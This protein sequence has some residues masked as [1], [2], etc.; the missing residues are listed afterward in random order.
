[1]KNVVI[2]GY[3]YQGIQA[4]KWLKKQN[5]YNFCGFVDNSVYKQG[6]YVGGLK[7]L[8]VDELAGMWDKHNISVIIAAGKWWEI[9][10]QCKKRGI[11][12]EGVYENNGIRRSDYMTFEQL[13]L[14]KEIKLYA[15]DICDLY[16]LNEEN[17]YGLSI[18][19]ADARHIFHNI[20]DSYPL[21][22][23]CISRY[24]LE[25]VLEYIPRE[26][27]KSTL[28][29]ICRILKPESL[30]RITV[31]DFNSPYLRE[32]TMMSQDGEFLFDAG[33]G[34]NYDENGISNGNIYFSTYEDFNEILKQTDF[35]SI[36]WLCYYT[37]DG[38]L[39]KEH[40]DMSKGYNN[41]VKNETDEDVYS[42][43]VDCYK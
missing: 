19:K 12:V 6:N 23:S 31:P 11:P 13:D 9:E 5:C 30:C 37:S 8:S 32:R 33:A 2:F 18:N 35:S 40:I 16:H 28:N 42:M 15:G 7:I 26:L 43:V 17:L 24:E 10:G 29:E 41:R 20:M 21:P 22:D 34:G 36:E 39:H 3:G 1:M 38:V 14:S 25:E 27:Q 4:H